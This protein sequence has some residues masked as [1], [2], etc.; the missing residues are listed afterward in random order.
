MGTNYI[1]RIEDVCRLSEFEKS[2]LRDV[3]RQFLFLANEYYLSL[4][5]WD[6]P[7]DPIRRIIIP[8]LSELDP[9]GRLD[10]SN[11]AAY[12]IQPGLQHKYRSTVI[13]LVSNACGGI[14]RY[15]FRKRIFIRRHMDLLNDLPAALRYIREHTEI[16]NVLVTGGDPLRLPTPQLE[17]IVARLREIPHVSVIRIGTK[18]PAYDVFRILE[19]PSLIRMIERYSEESRKIYIMSHF[20]HPRELTDLAVKATNLLQ[21]AGAI[22][23]NQTPLL[24][25]VND[26]PDV[27]AE[28]LRRLSFIGIV[29]YYIFQCRPAVGNRSFAVPIEEAYEII[30]RAKSGV[31]GLAKRVKYVMSHE[32]GKV[33]VVAKTDQ[34]VVFKYHRS[35]ADQFNDRVLVL[36]SNPGAYWLDDYEEVGLAG[37]P[38]ASLTC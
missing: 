3:S 37:E 20:S 22:L 19:D 24:R 18:I 30:E 12:T 15:C 33:E 28:L 4:I 2:Q 23:S 34:F 8:D 1:T 36:G 7:H 16:T 31:S 11:E 26:H 21:R 13:M 32:T 25:G 6:D 38:M 27:L 14:C 17:E 35:A 9:R 5:N 29:P 10:A